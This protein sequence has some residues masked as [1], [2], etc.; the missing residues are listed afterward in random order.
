MQLTLSPERL[1]ALIVPLNLA[2]GLS[3]LGQMGLVYPLLTLWLAS[4]GMSAAHIGVVA[5][6]VWVG[7]LLGGLIAP[8][9]LRRHGARTVAIVACLASALAALAM[10]QLPT[11]SVW[12]LLP[13]TALFGLA[14]GWRWVGIDSWFY[15]VLPEDARG[16]L[17]G[18]HESIIYLA[19]AAGLALIAVIGIAS[20][21]AFVTGALAAAAAVLPLIAIR[22]RPPDER[23][24]ISTPGGIPIRRAIWTRCVA[25]GTSVP[26]LLGGAA[27]GVNGA[28]GMLGV[29]FVKRGL[30]GEQAAAVLVMLGL[31]GLFSQWPLGWCADRYG[32]RTAALATGLTGALGGC[33]LSVAT[34][35]LWL[36]STLLGAAAASSLTVA[37]LITAEHA[38]RVQRTLGQAIAQLSVSFTAGS[39]LAPLVAGVAMETPEA[40][41][42]PLLAI[43]ICIL[44]WWAAGM[45][46]TRRAASQATEPA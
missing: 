26:A 5:G 46:A 14:C 36:P 19:E 38:A 37:S 41:A 20:G 18:I 31:G 42:F 16:R 6:G 32:S 8:G 9:A 10:P 3:H 15:A 35:L 44:F 1:A 22:Q 28:L 24:Q 17:I 45:A 13:V 21:L 7:M 2:S 4:R 33:L 25:L 30:S 12:T 27:G 23:N 43:A 34:P 29:Y 11:A 40:V 39:V